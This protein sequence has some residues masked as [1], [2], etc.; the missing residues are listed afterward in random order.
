MLQRWGAK[1]KDSRFQSDPAG[2]DAVSSPAPE[3]DERRDAAWFDSSWELRKGLVVA[4]VTEADDLPAEW[5]TA[6]VGG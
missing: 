6:A 3:R 1:P 5:R 2:D 4:E